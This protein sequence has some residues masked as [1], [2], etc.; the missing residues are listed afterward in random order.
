M[1][2]AI[3]FVVAV[4]AG[5]GSL[6]SNPSSSD[7]VAPAASSST[8]ARTAALPEPAAATR[9]AAA[10]QPTSRETPEGLLADQ[11]AA[12]NRGDL[13]GYM[14]GYWRSSELTFFS[15]ATITKG[16]Q[17]TLDRYRKRYQGEGRA[18]GQ[19]A[20]SEL[21]VSALGGGGFFARGRWLLTFKD[22]KPAQ[23]VFTLLLR[24]VEEGLRIVHDHSSGE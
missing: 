16:W 15:G 1:H 22:R 20:F 9:S 17:P 18:M 23:G 10:P 13:E 2:L 11:Q 21:E 7:P 14:A 12:W 8:T 4:G 3:L 24:R 6:A 19:L 5:S